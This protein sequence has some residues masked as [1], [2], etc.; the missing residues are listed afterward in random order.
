MMG[1]FSVLFTKGRQCGLF[2]TTAS[3]KEPHKE[4]KV[5]T[6]IFQNFK[7]ATV[8]ARTFC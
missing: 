1:M 7:N 8:H 3:A 4:A 2:E 5:L 6:S